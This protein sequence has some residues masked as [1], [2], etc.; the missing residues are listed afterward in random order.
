MTQNQIDEIKARAEATPP[1]PW[2]VLMDYG[3]YLYVRAVEVGGIVAKTIAPPNAEF[4]A[5]AREDIPALLAEV[6]RLRAK[7][8]R[9]PQW[10]PVTEALPG[11]RNPD[12]GIVAL[13]ENGVRVDAMHDGDGWLEWA[14]DLGE[15]LPL[16]GVTHWYRVPPPPN[17]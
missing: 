7:L 3:V 10:V 14:H 8:E 1:G 12:E 17:P 6:E 5:H 15:W 11:K 9:V 13:L 16:I 2:I 4:I